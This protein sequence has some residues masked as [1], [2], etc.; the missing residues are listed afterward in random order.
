MLLLL[1]SPSPTLSGGFTGGPSPARWLSACLPV[2]NSILQL[3]T[4]ISRPVPAISVPK[5]R[6]TEKESLFHVKQRTKPGTK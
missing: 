6:E 5:P 3:N 4:A 2:L 1:V